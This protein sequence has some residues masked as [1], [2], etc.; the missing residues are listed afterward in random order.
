LGIFSALQ[1]KTQLLIGKDFYN[2]L[3]HSKNYV[4]AE[5]FSKG[6]GI[7]TIPIYTR[8]LVPE[9]YGIF[10][11]LG[12]FLAIFGIIYSMGINSSVIR[13]YYEGKDDFDKFLGS[14]IFLLLLWIVPLSFILFIGKDILLKFFQIP[15]GMIYIGIGIV[16]FQIFIT[17]YEGLLQATK[18]SKKVAFLNII[19]KILLVIST[20]TLILIMQK[21]KYYGMAYATLF[22]TVLFG[23]YSIYQIGKKATICL[24][25][26]YIKYALILCIP[27]VFHLLSQYILSSFDLIIINQLVGSNETGLYS[28]AYNI[29]GIQNM[30]CFGMLYAWTPIFYEK[31]KEFKY[32]DLNALASKFARIIYLSAFALILFARELMIILADEQFHSALDIIPIVI[33]SYVFFFLYSLY[34]TFAFYKKKT[35]L[36]AL[37]TIIAGGINIGLNYW[38]I[39]LFGYKIAAWTT[40]ISYACLFVLHYLNARVILKTDWIISLK[41]LL[42]NLLVLTGFVLLFSYISIVTSNN[43]ILIPVKIFLLIALIFLYFGKKQFL[44]IKP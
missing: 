36:I 22:I 41:K 43:F 30:I 25:K 13:Y 37:F 18:Q 24:K 39:P 12:S 1:E 15:I 20:V 27:I 10:A 34:V 3:S 19:K 42:P 9:D 26:E 31:L 29:G 21:E 16:S 40:L 38:L 4:S 44:K 6:L 7:I 28:L 23:G 32:D 2:F 17:L 5:I 8:L 14:A 35:Q 11:I 33:M